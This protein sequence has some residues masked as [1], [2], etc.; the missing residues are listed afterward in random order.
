MKAIN[1]KW[2]Y[3][4]WFV[5][6]HERNHMVHN[7][8][9]NFGSYYSYTTIHNNNSWLKVHEIQR[10][11]VTY[12]NDPRTPCLSKA[13]EESMN[14]CIQHYIENEIGC[15]LPW[16][17][18]KTQL[19]RCIEK[20]QYQSFLDTSERI[21]RLSGFSIANKTGCLPSC[22]IHEYTMAVQDFFPV[23]F[24]GAATFDGYF[25]FPGGQY[26]E[27][28]YHYNYDFTSY[29]ADV[30]GLVGLFLGFS[31]LG[32]YDGLKNAYKNKMLRW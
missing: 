12:F 24:S 15:Q 6:I 26:W 31:M 3:G 4:E 1:G 25:F 8:P 20:E 7:S 13:R 10:K 30:G 32:C 22:K 16:N 28:V 29:I 27:K 17:K 9:H 14:K 2:D 5:F 21:S 18:G 11:E 23:E 19:P